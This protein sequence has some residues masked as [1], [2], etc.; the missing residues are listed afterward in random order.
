MVSSLGVVDVGDDDFVSGFREV[1]TL[2][3]WVNIGCYVLTARLSG[4]CPSGVTTSRPPFRSLPPKEAAGVEAR[5]HV[6][7]RQHPEAAAPAADE[8][9]RL[10]A[11][12]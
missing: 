8:A 5:G 10:A 6:A 4:G 1:P 9:T 7:D 2:P 12:P 3:Y 11:G